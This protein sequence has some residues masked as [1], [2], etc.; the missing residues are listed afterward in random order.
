MIKQIKNNAFA[1]NSLILFI[2]GMAVNFLNYIFHLAVGRMVSPSVYGEVESLVSLIVI[3]SVPSAAIMMVV[4]K[5]SAGFKAKQDTAGSW[6]ILR[7]FNRKLFVYGLPVFI[8]AAVFS[9]FIGNFLKIKNDWYL[10]W[11]WLM[12]FLSFW[13]AVSGGI[14]NG[15]QK[16]KA[17]SWMG[18]WGATAKLAL[19][20][21]IIKLGFAA[22]G[23]LGS[24]AAGGLV[25]YLVSL[26][27]L[28]FIWKN[29]SRNKDYVSSIDF[30]SVKKYIIPVFVGNLAVTILGNVDM[31]LAKHNLDAVTAGGYGALT[32]TSKIIFFATGALATV[33]FSMASESHYKKENSLRILKQGLIII[34]ALSLISVLVYFI[35]PHIVLGILFGA[36]YNSYSPFLGWFAIFISLFSITNL[37]FQ[38]LLSSNKTKVSYYLLIISLFEIMAI[39]FYGQDIL[40]I[41]KIIIAVQI[42]AIIISI[43]FLLSKNQKYEQIGLYN[44]A[45]L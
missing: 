39:V 12:A 25:S 22:G 45:G 8:L 28:R 33:L 20:I 29:K 14:L 10:V 2:G 27:A 4:T 16:F 35:F 13:A 44:S 9:P 7:Y 15:W 19:A 40:A 23:I 36:K 42:A 18:V 1:R 41:L 3:V 5:Y 11:V 6:E 37:I 38:Y 24:F 21:F 34:S 30:K 31:V 17:S 43:Y 32:I 26:Y